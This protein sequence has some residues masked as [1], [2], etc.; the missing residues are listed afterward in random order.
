MTDTR[1]T[2]AGVFGLTVN[3]TTE[4][5]DPAAVDF[6][7]I[8]VTTRLGVTYR[9]M[10]VALAEWDSSD[11]ADIQQELTTAGQI[12]PV[13]ARELFVPSIILSSVDQEMQHDLLG[14]LQGVYTDFLLG[15]T[16][17]VSTEGLSIGCGIVYRWQDE[18]N[19]D[20]AFADTTGGFGLVQARDGESHAQ[21]L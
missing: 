2:D 9:G 14:T 18:N 5:T 12:Q 21:C 4:Q 7:N 6:D 15:A 19:L 16:L 13:P 17:N 1:L 8:I 11:P 3:T 10:P 20:L